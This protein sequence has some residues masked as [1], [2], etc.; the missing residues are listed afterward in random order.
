VKSI[1]ARRKIIITA[2]TGGVGKTTLSASIGIR[3]AMDGRRVCVITID[4]AKRLATSLGMQALGDEPTDLTASL[5]EALSK[6]GLTLPQSAS[7]SALMPDTRSTFESFF[8]GLTEQKE[9]A[10]RMVRNPLFQIFAREFS[11]TNEYMA[12]QKL[13]IIHESGKYDCIILDTP[14]SRS[15][16]EFLDAPKLLSQLFDAN[17]IQWL[18]VP[19]NKIASA[20]MKKVLGLMEK[21]M[22]ASFMSHMLDFVTVLFEMRTGFMDHLRRMIRLMESEDV[23]VMLV[24]GAHS[25][26]S[27]ELSHFRG[28]LEKHGI[29]LDGM[30]VNRTIGAYRDEGAE[31]PP[32]SDAEFR[33][34]VDLLRSLKGREERGL[35]NLKKVVAGGNLEPRLMPEL[36]RD[37]HDLEDLVQIARRLD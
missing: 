33:S 19:A 37:V 12:L 20:A 30:V 8:R 13:S 36:A 21:L 15:T 28:H 1:L 32:A 6:Q 11:G 10:D 35:A 23:G 26:F 31:V 17:L 5:R 9:L 3:A 18:V 24:T 29:R 16:L 2:G 4:P 25:D 22:G 14:P 27:E 34:A 7:F